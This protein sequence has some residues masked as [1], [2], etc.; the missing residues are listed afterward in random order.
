LFIN[1]HLINDNTLIS[2]K[3]NLCNT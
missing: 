1:Q 2:C 3:R